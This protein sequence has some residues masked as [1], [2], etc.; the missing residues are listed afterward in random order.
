VR[1]ITSAQDRALTS[2]N[3]SEFLRVRVDRGVNDFVDLS[4]LE[5]RD[6]IESVT[7][8][9]TIDA[10]VT[11]ANVKIIRE[12]FE[13]SLATFVDGSKLNT[14]GTIIDISNPLVIDIATMPHEQVPQASDWVE[15]FRGQIEEIDWGKSPINIR[16]TD[17]GGDLV[18]TF[19]E[20]QHVYPKTTNSA[21]IQMEDVIQDILDDNN[22]S[23]T[24]A[25]GTY[26]WNGTTTV[27][28]T[29]T[30]DLAV[31]DFI[32][33]KGGTNASSF[34]K[35]LSIVPATSVVI[36][37]PQGRTIPT[38][39][40]ISTN[41]IPAAKRITLY[42]KNGTAAIP[43]AAAD[44]PGFQFQ[45][46]K[47]AKESLFNFIRVKIAQVIGWDFRYQWQDTVGSFEIQLLKPERPLASRGTLTFTGSPVNGE[48]MVVN[49]TT[50]TAKTAPIGANDF[51][52]GST[53]SDTA[54]NFSNMFNSTGGERDNAFAGPTAGV[55]DITWGTVGVAGN[56]IVFTEALSNAT[57]NG[58]GTLGGT[59][60]GLDGPASPDRT[61]TQS[62]YLDVSAL[63]VSRQDIRNV[64][65]LAFVDPTTD[66]RITTVVRKDAASI[67]KYG[68]RYMEI[69]EGSTSPIDTF[70]E[71]VD[72]ADAALDLAEPSAI[73]TVS[74]RFFWPAQVND[75]YKYVANGI[76]YT[77][78]QILSVVG[79]SHNLTRTGSTTNITVRGKPS[80]GVDRWL[81]IQGAAGLNPSID[82]IS[83][84]A[85]T[86]VAITAGVGT[87]VVTYDDP[88]TMDPPI[89]DW[90]TS[91]C[92][93]SITSGFTPSGATLQA[94]G[95]QT[96]FEIDG[97][98]P[99]ATYY[100]KIILIDGAGNKST[101]SSQVTASA[102]RVG[103]F[104][105]NIDTQAG[106]MIR[107]SDLNIFTKGTA[108]PPDF[109]TVTQGVWGTDI[110]P[111]EGFGVTG[112]V[113]LR[114]LFDSP[115]QIRSISSDFV[116]VTSGDILAASLLSFVPLGMSIDFSYNWYTSSKVFISSDSQT[117]ARADLAFKLTNPPPRNIPST[118]AFVKISV[119][120]TDTGLGSVDN[121][122]VD[123]INIK[124][125]MASTGVA[126]NTQWANANPFSSPT[127]L[128]LSFNESTLGFSLG[129]PVG[130]TIANSSEIVIGI[131]GV[132][133][134]RLEVQYTNTSSTIAGDHTVQITIESKEGSAAS[135]SVLIS[136]SDTVTLIGGG[137]AQGNIP[138]NDLDV[139]MKNF[140]AGDKV[141]F[142][143]ALLSAP[144][145]S[146]MSLFPVN[147]LIKQIIRNGYG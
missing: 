31:G 12:A 113:S 138:L 84:I 134:V 53:V 6:W 123:R 101:I 146:A 36:D 107:N 71:A 43:F 116:P 33:N 120:A 76:H 92:H 28:T 110:I 130:L 20:T 11:T 2:T 35:I 57:A 117:D 66:A 99:G 133:N 44:S 141:R 58:A 67:A 119:L 83:D 77:T 34:F 24:V 18:A 147:V 102:Q 5:G 112:N 91:E 63:K 115:G 143:A 50:F 106:K 137:T 89:T 22:S 144:G 55:V 14:S 100:A 4:D 94:I 56:S 85:P 136:R 60:A 96:R 68:R 40:G 41:H 32:G 27:T 104:H 129:F 38:A 51:L 126:H 128:P 42:S 105:E 75:T 23:I 39:A 74:H 80:G 1:V 30:T 7:Y 17:Q 19:I 86:N 145:G 81:E 64:V 21:D 70:E 111:R 90:E 10:P 114:F 69:T 48:T 79:I 45:K 9:E 127:L 82:E 65:H 118:A 93:V 121:V 140:E 29:I 54:T 16:A 73:Q 131:G 3:R 49:G 108:F 62:E 8:G 78:D 59:R 88:R 37:N 135:F 132:Y 95:K 109:W 52:I 15:V 139:S 13:L 142:Q 46:F 98:I 72:L 97:L 25:A 124:R 122:D 26:T 61:F 87:I 125:G 47:S 103:P